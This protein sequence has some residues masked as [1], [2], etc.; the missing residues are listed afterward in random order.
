MKNLTLGINPSGGAP[1]YAQLY[2]RIVGGISR[3]EIKAGEKLPSKR[4]LAGNLG[5]SVNTVDTAYQMLTAEGYVQ[6]KPKSGFFVM[7][8]ERLESP[9]PGS[10]PKTVPAPAH[11]RIDF[12]TGSVDTSLFPYK[13]W[14]RIQREILSGHPELL[15]L[16]EQN[17]D[18]ELR[19]SIARYLHE[20]RGVACSA[21]Q[22]IVGAG[23]EYLLSQIAVMFSASIF[24][25]ENPGYPKAAS[26]LKNH[27]IDPVFVPV[28]KD[29]L[30]VSGLAD[31]DIVYVTPS[32][33]FPTGATMP[34]GRR[35][36]LLAWACERRGRYIIEDDYDSEF[37]FDVRP[38]PSLQ[39][40]DGAGRVIYIGTFSRSLSPS[41]RIAYMALPEALL[42]VYRRYF[43]GYSSTV[44][45]FEQHTLR[46]FID[47]GHFSRHLNR[48][49]VIYRARRDC[50]IKGLAASLGKE[51]IRISGE[52]TGLHLVLQVKA[53]L[54]ETELAGRAAAAGVR[55]TGL[56]K[57][58]RPGVEIPGCSLVLGYSALDESRIAEGC[59]A[60]KSAWG[61]E[62]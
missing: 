24:A 54:D 20:Y 35:Q 1:L 47:G 4:A 48:T 5:V 6:A 19:E 17:G 46:R 22:I 8:I 39:G 49:R 42:P 34:I 18:A 15:N 10:A 53:G 51:R 43:A 36:E 57:Y 9:A 21:G 3:G 23:M 13:T 38:V 11:P 60:L 30:D 41:I 2:E 50:L 29:G 58:Y 40:L 28:D 56:S 16:G 61:L 27:K 37:R 55:L 14:G 45:R 62:G 32:H 31:A 44:S 33:Q 26:I 59:A 52:H 12:G 7:R 25:L